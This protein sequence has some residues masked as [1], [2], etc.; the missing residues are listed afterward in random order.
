MGLWIRG[1]RH[2]V[3]ARPGRVRGGRGAHPP[4]TRI[5]RN[6]DAVGLVLNRRGRNCRCP[7]FCF[8]PGNCEK[9]REC[10]KIRDSASRK[11]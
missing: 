10:H 6:C 9:S 2:R 5:S 1:A 3:C 8:T 4:V 11:L 7:S